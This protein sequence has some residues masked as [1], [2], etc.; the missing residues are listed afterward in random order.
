MD[1][2]E[3]RK[4][5]DKMVVKLASILVD[6]VDVADYMLAVHAQDNPP[7]PRGKIDDG[8]AAKIFDYAVYHSTITR[9]IERL[10]E[11]F[12]D[13]IVKQIGFHPRDRSSWRIKFFINNR[14][15]I[16]NNATGL[17]RKFEGSACSVDKFNSFLSWYLRVESRYRRGAQL[18][19]LV[20]S[21]IQA[22]YEW[23]WLK[24]ESLR[25]W[26][27]YFDAL[28][29]LFSGDVDRFTEALTKLESIYD[30]NDV[31]G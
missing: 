23:S 14:S 11:Q 18:F 19:P 25:A 1:N 24:P 22:G 3:I 31:S 7:Q 10:G 12:T 20:G 9:H 15:F 26:T 13:E 2:S 30:T 21:P 16:K 6:T 17:I 5:T 29:Y 28:P 4:H 8:G 27:E